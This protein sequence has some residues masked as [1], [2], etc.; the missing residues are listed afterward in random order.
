[1]SGTQKVNSHVVEYINDYLQSEGKTQFAVLLTGKW[2]SGKTWFI[3]NFIKSFIKEKENE[4]FY[5]KKQRKVVYVSL[6]G[7]NTIEDVN[8]EIAWAVYKW[9]EG[10]KKIADVGSNIIS[11]LQVLGVSLDLKEIVK[12]FKKYEKKV[13]NIILV[14]DDL[15]RCPIDLVE[16]FGLIN[17]FV[18]HNELKVIII[19][20][21]EKLK[22]YFESEKLENSGQDFST[23]KDIKEKII[24]HTLEILPDHESALSNFFSEFD[25]KTREFFEGN[26][27]FIYKIFLIAGTNNLRSLKAGLYSFERFWKWLSDVIKDD[28]GYKKSLLLTVIMYEMEI[29]A[30]RLSLEALLND[31]LENNELN[32]KK[33]EIAFSSYEA[34]RKELEK[35]LKIYDLTLFLPEREI[36]NYFKRGYINLEHIINYMKEQ[37]GTSEQAKISNSEETPLWIQLW[38]VRGLGEKELNDLME[39]MK[40][41]FEKYEIKRIGEFL[42]IVAQLIKLQEDYAYT[43]PFIN[44][45]YVDFFKKYLDKLAKKG[46]WDFPNN[47]DSVRKWYE[48]PAYKGYE[49][50]LKFNHSEFKKI[51]LYAQRL[52]FSEKEVKTTI[53]PDLIKKLQD[54]TK[55][56][57]YRAW[58]DE[59]ADMPVLHLASECEMAE[60]LFPDG[61]MNK[62]AAHFFEYRY[63]HINSN[64]LMEE[65]NWFEKFK[66]KLSRRVK[67]QKPPFSKFGEEYIKDIFS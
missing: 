25:T 62:T 45:D 10:A 26:K 12:V 16:K 13:E 30:G 22:E 28:E 17:K 59:H 41:A 44:T 6:N 1:M 33:F 35:Y 4:V 61:G 50:S 48:Y 66:E 42:H 31:G 27:E 65:E 51:V 8:K 43:A 19:A 3:K 15:E 58:H 24:G 11:G 38:N 57:D 49:Y 29:R 34:E 47:N 63:S 14:F 54:K 55:S 64:S 9:L 56:F 21:E 36:V 52:Q 23:Y 32:D 46:E 20:N 39:K 2:G 60:I 40:M 37:V 67:Q 53:L 18:E 7:V 5:G